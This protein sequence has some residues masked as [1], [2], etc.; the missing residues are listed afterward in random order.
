[1]MMMMMKFVYDISLSLGVFV[2]V[3]VI[4]NDK[5]GCFKFSVI[6]NEFYLFLWFSGFS[7]F[8]YNVGYYLLEDNQ[9]NDRKCLTNI[10]FILYQINPEVRKLVRRLER[11]HLNILKKKQFTVFNQPYIY[12]YIYIM[13]SATQVLF[14]NKIICVSISL[15]L[16]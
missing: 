15:M 11:L 10:G 12:I 16:L 13:D 7:S 8:V 14:L 1:M 6:D 9:Q 3:C 2:G 5:V 4:L